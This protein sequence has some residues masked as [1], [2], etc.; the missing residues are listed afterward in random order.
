MDSKKDSEKKPLVKKAS[1]TDLSDV[2]AELVKAHYGITEDDVQAVTEHI[3]EP[4][5]CK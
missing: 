3:L 4:S 1:S 2:A 5:L